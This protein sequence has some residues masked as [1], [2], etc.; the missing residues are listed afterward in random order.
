MASKQQRSKQKR[1]AWRQ[2]LRRWRAS[3][4]SVRAFCHREGISE[5]S[6]YWW[7]RQLSGKRSASASK[8]SG[9][10]SRQR[11]STNSSGKQRTTRAAPAGFA[12]LQLSGAGEPSGEIIELVL[13]TGERLRVG[14]AVSPDHLQ[15]VLTVLQT[16]LAGGSDDSGGD[17]C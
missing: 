3:G 8:A 6:F 11:A 4:E 5:P 1:Q 13:T 2:T 14:P 9:R 7:R 15:R 16:P 12:E 10:E 17:R